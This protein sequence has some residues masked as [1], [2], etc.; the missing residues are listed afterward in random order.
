MKPTEHFHFQNIL[1]IGA[2]PDDIEY[3]C[4]G[5]LLKQ[6]KLNSKISLFVASVGSKGDLSSGLA[7]KQESM[8][9]L[10]VLSPEHVFFREESG[11]AH[12]NLEPLLDTLFQFIQ[13]VQPD[14]ILTMSQHDTHQEHQNLH[15]I[16]MAAAR[17]SSASILCYSILSNTLKFSPTVFVDVKDEMVAKKEA[18]QKHISQRGKYYMSDEY[19][20][21]FHSH[22]YASLHGLRYCEAYEVERLL[23]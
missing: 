7:R 5:L 11:I 13:K 16:S 22:K 6:K 9:A 3:G 17:R 23:I 20:E 15:T 21:I 18:L 10:S 1:A 12:N 8:N 2:H 19:L 4:L 14:L